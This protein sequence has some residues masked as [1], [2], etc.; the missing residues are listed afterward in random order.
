MQAH[1]VPVD[2]L[3]ASDRAA[4]FSLLSN[5]FEQVSLA[6]FEADLAS[7]NWVV[8]LRADQ[9]LIGFST[10]RFYATQ[11][12]GEAV[13][14]VYSGDTIVAPSGWSSSLLP[15][16]WIAA[17][18]WL[19]GKYPEGKLYWL[20]ISSG[21]RTYRFLP[22]F[23]KD[24]YPRYDVP[25]PPA[26]ANVLHTVASWQFQE[27][28]NPVTGIVR[29]AQPQVLCPDLRGIP[30]ERLSDPHVQFF[31]TRN[32]GYEQGDELACLTELVE[33]NLTSAG[34]RMW[35]AT[36]PLIIGQDER[37]SASIGL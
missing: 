29:F 3:R 24:F 22:T 32:P 11:V 25:T 37:E 4:M 27:A 2:Q 7:K 26:I 28:Y 16:A 23:W 36:T 18:N 19:R 9:A 34:K 35:C 17:I 20:L 1:L 33:T 30:P 8:L 10:M 31:Q 15:R 6:L 12:A 21:F 5:H 14:I 13:T